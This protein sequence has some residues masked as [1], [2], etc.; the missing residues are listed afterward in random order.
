[1]SLSSGLLL[2]LTEA[3]GDFSF[4]QAV[5]TGS[6][7]WRLVGHASYL[8]LSEVLF[9]L[10]Q[11]EKL[12]IL[13]AYWDATSNVVT[14]AIGWLWFGEMIT[15]TQHAGFILTLVGSWLLREQP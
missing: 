15:P 7:E 5:T 4:K 2:T 12:S 1:M 14:Y 8:G 3:V 11:R 9:T 10:L 6:G 13:N